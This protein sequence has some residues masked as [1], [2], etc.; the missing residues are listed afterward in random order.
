MFGEHRLRDM[1][2]QY[3]TQDASTILAEI[4][5]GLKRFTAQQQDDMTLVVIKVR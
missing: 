3:H 4:L 1:L 5:S 2:R